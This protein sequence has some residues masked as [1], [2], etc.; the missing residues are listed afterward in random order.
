[1]PKKSV[2]HNEAGV[3]L[4]VFFSEDMNEEDTCPIVIENAVGVIDINESSPLFNV[5]PAEIHTGY[6]VNTEDGSIET[7]PEPA[8]PP[9]GE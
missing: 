4:S 9:E 3:I 6:R 7:I 1:M 5:P 8:E 2:I